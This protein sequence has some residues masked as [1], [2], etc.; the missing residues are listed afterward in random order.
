MII[1][2]EKQRKVRAINELLMMKINSRFKLMALKR[3][4]SKKHGF[5]ILANS[6]ILNEYKNQL[7]KGAI[8]RLPVL[9]KILRKRT[10]RTMSGIAPVAVLT[11][12]Y[13]CPGQCAYCPTEKDVPQSY[14]SNEPAVMRAIRC[15]FDP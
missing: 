7:A 3:K 13:P 9:E 10:V 4:L 15:G 1:N 11:K 8:G 14:L 5:N 6:E 12:P 2:K